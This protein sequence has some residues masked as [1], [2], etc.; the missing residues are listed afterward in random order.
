MKATAHFMCWL[1]YRLGY[2]GGCYVFAG[3]RAFDAAGGFDERYFASEEIHFRNALKKSGRFAIVPAA[4]IS[5]G[6]KMRLFTP[7]QLLRQTLTFTLRGFSALRRRE[8]L[9]L[10]YG[11]QR[12]TSDLRPPLNGGSR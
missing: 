4:V 2:A 6:R 5:S 7:V 8:G 10:W 12:E 9:E 1:L 3:R 11:G